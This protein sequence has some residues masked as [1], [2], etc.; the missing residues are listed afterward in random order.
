MTVSSAI[1]K[2][3]VIH[4]RMRPKRHRFR[5]NVFTMLIDLDELSDLDKGGLLFGHN[6]PAILSFFDRD[7][8]PASGEALRPWVEAR[9]RDAGLEPDGGAI[10]LLCY[11]R[12]LGYVFNPLS[13]YFCYRTDGD[14]SAIVYEVCNTFNERHAYVIR[15]S[16]S[17]PSVVRQSCDKKMYVSPFI[18]METRYH[19]RIVPPADR[20]NIVIRQ[21]D[22]EGLLLAASFSGDKSPFNRRTLARCLV[23]FPFLTVKIIAAIH[24]EAVLLWT[25]GLKVFPHTPAAR[26]VDSSIGQADGI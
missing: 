7:H 2:G 1:F 26:A 16:N 14:L 5:Y 11:P 6:R 12:I 25:K 19:F 20:I 24:W 13:V 4:E 9:M 21:E 3:P 22:E 8:G 23:A 15:A 10:R 17:G 18:A